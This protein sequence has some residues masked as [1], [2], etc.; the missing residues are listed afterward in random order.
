M[1]CTN[2]QLAKKPIEPG[3]ERLA[4]MELA[5]K[6]S[7]E[8]TSQDENN[9]PDQCGV[10]DIEH[11]TRKTTKAHPGCPEKQRV[12]EDIATGHAGASESPPLPSVILCA[13]QEVYQEHRRSRR[14][15]YHQP[16]A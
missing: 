14:C 11:R 8:L 13:Q 7:P 12:E 16:V 3:D 2:A 15:D 9:E 10:S 1:R 5:G 6:D 4:A